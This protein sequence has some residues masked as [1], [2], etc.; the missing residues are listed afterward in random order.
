MM[1]INETETAER[2]AEIIRANRKD[3][4]IYELRLADAVIV[5]RDRLAKYEP[6]LK[7][8]TDEAFAS[9]SFYTDKVAE[10]I[11]KKVQIEFAIID[12]V[13]AHH[14]PRKGTE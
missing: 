11:V 14:D 2:T 13:M 3:Y 8:A 7:S 12:T 4:N 9:A 1:D 5:L 10:A 6:R